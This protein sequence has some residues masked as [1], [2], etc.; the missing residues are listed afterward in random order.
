MGST[1]QLEVG[2]AC[3]IALWVRRGSTPPPGPGGGTGGGTKA[4]RGEGP[5]LA[6]QEGTKTGRGGGGGAR[7]ARRGGTETGRGEGPRLARRGDGRGGGRSGRQTRRGGG[8]HR[9]MQRGCLMDST[10]CRIRGCFRGCLRTCH[11]VLCQA[12]AAGGGAPSAIPTPN[13][14]VRNPDTKRRLRMMRSRRAVGAPAASSG[15]ARAAAP[16][17]GNNIAQQISNRRE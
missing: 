4:G 9:E 8:S 16:P 14:A 10:P 1:K 2:S 5:R 13:G 3:D 17:R 6:R 11:L 15:C 12:S 7:R